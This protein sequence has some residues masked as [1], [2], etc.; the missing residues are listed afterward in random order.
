VQ[1]RRCFGTANSSQRR[2][3]VR[4]HPDPYLD[5]L[6]A[7]GLAAEEALV[8]E[9][10]PSGI[11]AARAAGVAVVALATSQSAAVLRAAGADL[12]IDTFHD[13]LPAVRGEA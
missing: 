7:L 2:S 3:P 4:R 12:V 6:A 1:W 11:A 13:I 8:F 9:D 5:A 10:S